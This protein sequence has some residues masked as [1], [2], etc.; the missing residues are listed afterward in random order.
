LPKYWS[1]AAAGR[2]TVEAGV[3]KLLEDIVEK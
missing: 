2:T 1:G 3:K